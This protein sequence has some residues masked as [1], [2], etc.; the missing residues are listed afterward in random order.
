MKKTIQR[1]CIACLSSNMG[2]LMI[3]SHSCVAVN[4]NPSD[5]M[6]IYVHDA[7]QDCGN[8]TIQSEDGTPIIKTNDAFVSSMICA[9]DSNYKT[10]ILLSAVPYD[11]SSEKGPIIISPY[12]E[13]GD[14]SDAF[15]IRC[16]GD[17]LCSLNDEGSQFNRHVYFC[18]HSPAVV[19][20][21][22]SPHS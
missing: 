9:V 12:G 13:Y 15:I 4:A 3:A 10:T 11:R 6:S 7:L 2:L 21:R 1:I 19:Q 17:A 14:D 22:L 5:Y 18:S 20:V 8:V 16:Q